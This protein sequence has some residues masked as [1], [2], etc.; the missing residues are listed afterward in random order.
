M[1][2]KSF[3]INPF[4]ITPLV[5]LFFGNLSLGLIIAG[6]SVLIW[7]IEEGLIFISLTSLML[8]L[9]TGNIN[10]EII[11]IFLITVALIIKETSTI[12]SKDN[13]K[14]Y[15]YWG[16][17][18]IAFHPVWRFLLG[19]IP[20][21]LLNDFNIAGQFVVMAGIAIM[22]VRVWQSRKLNELL[23][24]FLILV[25]AILAINGFWFAP[26]SWLLGEVLLYII[27]SKELTKSRYFV[28]VKTF[29]TMVVFLI[30]LLIL[31]L[32]YYIPVIVLPLL[33]LVSLQQSTP[34]PMMEVLY[35]AVIIG[36]V[37][38]RIGL[39]V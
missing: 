37:A 7:G 17:I 26:I 14:R 25:T 18:L 5:A 33:F 35:F 20:A 13:L 39:V 6:Y 12:N 21:G 4:I 24:F 9:L 10:L 15:L 3:F 22:L 36:L 32:N 11:F 28:T 31:P 38:G 8:V 16:I 2:W 34:I 23:K 19:L 29:F 30:S 1:N 27:N